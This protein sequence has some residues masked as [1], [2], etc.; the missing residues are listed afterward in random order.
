MVLVAAYD[1]TDPNGGEKIVDVKDIENSDVILLPE[2]LAE[3]N[4]DSHMPGR[5]H[6]E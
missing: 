2:P 3:T 5:W 6:E 1:E 4:L